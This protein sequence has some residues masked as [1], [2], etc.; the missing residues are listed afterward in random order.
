MP[1]GPGCAVAQSC[2]TSQ[3]SFQDWWRSCQGDRVASQVCL[4]WCWTEAGGLFSSGAPLRPSSFMESSCSP[5]HFLWSLQPPSWNLPVHLFGLFL[6]LLLPSLSHSLP[7]PMER[8]PA[9]DFKPCLLESHVREGCEVNLPC[10]SQKQTT[11]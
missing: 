9:K 7:L 2:L 4:G 1:L 10:F 11:L 6:L 8:L 3:L 5:D